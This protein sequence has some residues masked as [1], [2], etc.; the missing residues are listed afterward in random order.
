MRWINTP[1]LPGKSNGS[2]RLW[3]PDCPPWGFVWER[4][5]WPKALG[6]KVY[7]NRVKEIGWYRVDLTP[8]ADRD[9]LFEG[10][11]KQITVFH[12]HGDTFDLPP[13]TVRL[14]QSQLCRN[15]AFRYGRSAYG[16][17]FHIEMTA[18]LIDSWLAQS[19]NC[20]ELADAGVHRSAE[21]PR[22]N[23]HRIANPAK[24]WPTKCSGDS[25]GCAGKRC[26][27]P[28]NAIGM[29]AASIRWSLIVID[30]RPTTNTS[31]ILS[32]CGSTALDFV[33]FPLTAL[34]S[35]PRSRSDR[36]RLSEKQ[37]GLLPVHST[38]GRFA[39][40]FPAGAAPGWEWVDWPRP[41]RA[42]KPRRT[43]Q[44]CRPGFEQ[45]I[46]TKISLLR[47]DGQA[48]Q[49]TSENQ[50]R[51]QHGDQYRRL[52]HGKDSERIYGRVYLCLS[53]YLR[54]T[55]TQEKTIKY[56]ENVNMRLLGCMRQIYR[57]RLF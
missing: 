27:S 24:P 6:A 30:Q 13:G 28:P 35:R 25:F 46:S 20:G 18:E 56:P 36:F 51:C 37:V 55:I 14:A 1:T 40:M 21:N 32:G 17:Q 16:L 38:R 10:G 47:T 44:H 54:R 22:T 7:P 52:F 48:R 39:K 12:W 41:S 49:H 9:A 43:N 3:R 5:Y 31:V 29:L 33:R 34:P 50:P 42:K 57:S 8:H 26:E 2:S 11:G 45:G 15:Q 19:A 53:F 23:P 4:S